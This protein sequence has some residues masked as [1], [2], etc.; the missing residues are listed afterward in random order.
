MATHHTA[1]SPPAT[2]MSSSSAPATAGAPTAMLLA[3]QGLDVVIVDRAELPSDTLST[4][5]LSRGASC[6]SIAGASSARS[7]PAARRRSGRSPST[8]RAGR[9]SR[10]SRTAPAST[11]CS[12]RAGHVL[13]AI[14][15]A[16]AEE[17][18]ATVQTGVSVT[19]TL[20]RRH[21][22]RHR[23]RRCETADGTRPRAACPLRHRRRRRPLSCRP[24]R[25]RPARSRDRGPTGSTTYAYVA[26]LGADGFEFYLGRPRLRRRLPDPRRRGQR[27]DRH[28]AAS[29]SEARSEPTR[30]S[31]S[32]GGPRRSWRRASG[33]SDHVAAAHGDGSPEPRPRSRRTRLGARRRRRLPPRPDHRARDHRR[34]PRRRAARPAAGPCSA[35]RGVRGEGDGC[36]RRRPRSLAG[37]DLR[38][39]LAAGPAPTA[40]A[41]RRAPEAAQRC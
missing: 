17:A 8:S 20:T 31:T 11:T 15:L 2:P 35:R 36:L 6:S 22:S 10:R 40:R 29:P 4:H 16:A 13:D 12:R 32:S 38:R 7:S 30:S 1:D 28:S 5:A 39:H 9:S 25:R 34:V 21:R 37:P 19:G 18:G 27:L 23:R 41:V 33:R 14:L 24:Q 26:G 3:R